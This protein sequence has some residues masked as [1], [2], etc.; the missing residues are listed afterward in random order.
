M[1]VT[2]VRRGPV[3]RTEFKFQ[4]WSVSL[5]VTV[6]IALP[7]GPNS[8][9]TDR[10]PLFPPTYT[11][12]PVFLPVRPSSRR[13]ETSTIFHIIQ[14]RERRYASEE[15]GRSFIPSPIYPVSVCF[16]SLGKIG[17]EIG[18][19]ITQRPIGEAIVER[20][21]GMGREYPAWKERENGRFDDKSIARGRGETDE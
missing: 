12:L 14:I 10:S 19:Q 21:R 2:G 16:R 8:L 6:C 13:E 11:R 20:T 5:G 4:I 15:I 18:A 1:R 3:R 17:R 9:H 7:A